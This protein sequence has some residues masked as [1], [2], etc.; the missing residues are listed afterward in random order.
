M[1]AGKRAAGCDLIN[2]LYYS[3]LTYQEYRGLKNQFLSA[4]AYVY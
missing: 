4:T 1:L 2:K 3:D